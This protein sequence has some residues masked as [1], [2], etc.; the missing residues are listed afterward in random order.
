MAALD[1]L[2]LP[3]FSAFQ[4]EA[5]W[6]YT[7]QNYIESRGS[8]ELAVAFARFFWPEFVERDGCILF[9]NG[10][11]EATYIEWRTKSSG[12]V[13]AIER[14]MNHVHLE[15]LVPSDTTDFGPTVLP[16]LAREVADMWKHRAKSVYPARDFVV[17]VN[18][19]HDH[20]RFQ[21]C[22]FQVPS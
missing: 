11:D 9:A 8:F 6:D 15:D 19:D 2:D 12:N 21:V 22:L 17:E 20:G 16:Y 3:D 18:V 4:R 14:M 10:F 7:L 1:P 13:E 5:R